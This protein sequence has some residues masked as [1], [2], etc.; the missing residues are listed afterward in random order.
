MR[1]PLLQASWHHSWFEVGTLFS[2][3]SLVFLQE[4]I[5]YGSFQKEDT[6]GGKTNEKD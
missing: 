2:A 1:Y 3:H 4:K 6:V 5:N